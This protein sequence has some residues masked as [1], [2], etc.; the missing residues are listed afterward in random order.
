MKQVFPMI[1]AGSGPIWFFLGIAVLLVVLISLFGYLAWASRHVK[2]EA[3]SVGLEIKG[4]LYARRIPLVSLRL[5]DASVVDLTHDREHQLKWRTNGAGLPGYSAGWFKLRNGEKS[6]VF[7]TD[8][9]RVLHIPTR[10][11]YSLLLSTANPQSLLDALRRT[12]SQ[13]NPASG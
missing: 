5:E 3:S 12:A 13:A 6:L 11:G 8:P 1:P 10:D 4:D 9:R 2:F 7:V